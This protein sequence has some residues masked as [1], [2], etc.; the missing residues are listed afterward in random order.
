MDTD[1]V[2]VDKVVSIAAD[3]IAAVDHQDVMP[4]LSE[5]ACHN[6]AGKASANDQSTPHRMLARSLIAKSDQDVG[7]PPAIGAADATR[8]AHEALPRIP[9]H[10]ASA[11][12]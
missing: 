7:D 1:S 4:C 9:I 11:E 3:V 10:S 12:G 6:S 8:A 5:F 2:I